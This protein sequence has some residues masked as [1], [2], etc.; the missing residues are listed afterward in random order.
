MLVCALVMACGSAGAMELSDPASVG[1]S[2]TPPVVAADPARPATAPS[3]LAIQRVL[4]EDGADAGL[5][6]A[7]RALDASRVAYGA[8]D[9]RTLIPLI[10]QANLRQRGGDTAGALK[11]YRAAID[12]AEAHGG[13]R[14]AQLFAAWYGTGYTY[15]AA[16]QP[17]A[18]APA[19]ETALQLHRVNEGLFSAEQLEVLHALAQAARAIGKLEDADALQ[20]RRIEVAERVHGAG[21]VKVADTYISVGRWYREIGRPENAVALHALAVQTLERFPA[22][23]AGLVGALLELARSGTGRRRDVDDLPILPSLRPPNALARAEKLLDETKTLTP[24]QQADLRLRLGDAQQLLGREDAALRNYNK[25]QALLTAQ[26]KKSPFDAPA[27]IRL[28]LPVIEPV[29]GPGGYLLAEFDVDAKGRTSNVRIVEAQPSSLP[30][31]LRNTLI[32]ALK[33]AELRPRLDKNQAVATKGL[34]YRLAVRGDS[35]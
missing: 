11:D 20:R 35:A 33:A 3:E 21:T 10:N 8:K 5:I 25:A 32:S 34:R 17:Q 1:E 7:T 15:L 30:P 13:P 31:K 27:F 19:L 22:E 16:N 12:L 14:A 4:E 24:A 23:Q 9:A 29:T 2:V 28:Q 18:A 6:L 26:N